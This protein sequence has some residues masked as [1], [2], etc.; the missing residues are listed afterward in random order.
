MSPA[1]RKL[2][3]VIFFVSVKHKRILITLCH[4][5]SGDDFS[6]MSQ[7]LEQLR[8]LKVVAPEEELLE[9]IQ[10]RF[11][12]IWMLFFVRMLTWKFWSLALCFNHA[13]LNSILLY[14]HLIPF[15]PFSTVECQSTAGGSTTQRASHQRTCH[16]FSP[17]AVDSIEHSTAT[18]QPN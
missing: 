12:Y 4:F 18:G 14:L 5:R 13:F 10:V 1:Y 17:A 11:L 7:R 6:S 2:I 3:C 9:F 8:A 15:N 16:L